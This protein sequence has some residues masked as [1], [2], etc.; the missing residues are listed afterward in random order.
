[1]QGAEFHTLTVASVEPL[2]DDS[3]AV[4]FDIPEDLATAFAHMPGEHLIV[5]ATIDGEDVRRSYSICSP[6]GASSPRVG[7]KLLKGGAFSTFAHEHLS[8]GDVLEVTPPAGEFTLEPSASNR[9][10]YVAF[11]AGSGITP[12]LSM[13]WSVL[14]REPQSMFT[15]I[16]GNKDGRSVM[17]LDELDALKG[18]YPDRFVLLHILSRES[19][20]I[21]LLEGR[22]DEAKVGQLL[23]TVID[24]S[25]VDSW[26][27]CG[28][29]GM[30]DA[31][32]STLE[33]R[34]I[35]AASINE[36]LFFAGDVEEIEVAADDVIGSKV[37]FTL[38]GRTSTAIVAADGAP[39]LD[40]V[41]AIRPEGP[42]SCRSGACASCRAQ[43]T[44]GEVRMDRNWSLSSQEV[45][46][47][48]ILTCQAHP[49]SDVVEL[50]Y[51]V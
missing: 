3:V 34:G 48:Q 15:L 5:R 36:E 46:S 35:D 39:I 12:V 17:F 31:V 22:I 7:I 21:P 42:F 32:R 6:V 26:Y 45:A 38:D 28:P 4:T 1:M 29:K 33:Q 14:E 23:G 18:S 16:Y 49:V 40:H 13:I 19:H 47:G 41:L 2:T 11:A 51:D 9:S 8:A 50:T 10:H 30:V 27:L 20:T 25:S 37:K 24:P 44:V 43:L